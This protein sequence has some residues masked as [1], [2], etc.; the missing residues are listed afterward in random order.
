LQLHPD[1]SDEA[2]SE[3]VLE[4]Y[5]VVDLPL[6]PRAITP[7]MASMHLAILLFV[8][9]LVFVGVVIIVMPTSKS[10][11]ELLGFECSKIIVGH[12]GGSMLLLHVGGPR[13]IYGTKY[14]VMIRDFHI[15]LPAA[16]GG[17]L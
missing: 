17:C 14:E 8:G 3:I 11:G 5:L 15:P 2:S 7:K 12:S 4:N 10:G 6:E 1:S 13:P 9:L 16:L